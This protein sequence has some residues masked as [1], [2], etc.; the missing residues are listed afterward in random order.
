MTFCACSWLLQN[1][2]ALMC[3][4]MSASCSSGRAASKIPPQFLRAGPQTVVSPFEIL[5]WG[6]HVIVLV[7]LP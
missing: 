1:V 7:V 6:G 5:E 2:G 4:S 3:F